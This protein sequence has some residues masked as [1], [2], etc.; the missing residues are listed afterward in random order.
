MLSSGGGVRIKV[1]RGYYSSAVCKSLIMSQL[2]I[3][4]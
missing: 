1:P 2:A 4:C 3:G